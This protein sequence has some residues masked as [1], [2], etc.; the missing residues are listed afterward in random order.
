MS[1][2]PANTG[3][4]IPGPLS[5]GGRGAS[6]FGVQAFLIIAFLFLCGLAGAGIKLWRTGPVAEEVK[7]PAKKFTVVLAAADLDVGREIRSSDM[8]TLSA[9]V[10]T[11]IV[12]SSPGR[13]VSVWRRN[14]LAELSEAKSTRGHPSHWIVCTRTALVR[15]RPIC[16]PMECGL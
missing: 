16:S 15:L 12:H 7:P 14:L 3:P 13:P 2:G 10:P 1:T 4:L 5:A 9:L 11:S 6:R 8:Y